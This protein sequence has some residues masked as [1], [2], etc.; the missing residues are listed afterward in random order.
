MYIKEI[1]QLLDKHMAVC[2]ISTFH[3]KHYRSWYRYYK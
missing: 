3:M 2:H 1:R